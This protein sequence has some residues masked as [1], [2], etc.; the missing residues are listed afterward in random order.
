MLFP[1]PSPYLLR[2]TW[3]LHGRERFLH[4]ASYRWLGT[5]FAVG[6][7]FQQATVAP[8]HLPSEEPAGSCLVRDEHNY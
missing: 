1:L 5:R 8:P 6:E 3:H 7:M 4:S 2:L